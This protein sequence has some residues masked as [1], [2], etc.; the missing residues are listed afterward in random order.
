MEYRD[1]GRTGWKVS[2]IGFGAWAIGS[3]WGKVDETVSLKTLHKALDMGVNFFDT[4]DVYG[5]EPMVGQLRR[6]RSEP[7]YI[8]TK[9]GMQINPSIKGY[10]RRNL[11]AQLNDCLA[12]LG[13]ESIDLL[14]LHCPP[15]EVYNAGVCEILDDFV[16]QGKIRFY[17]TSVETLEQA[18]KASEFPNMQSVQL[19]FNV[20]RQKP[21]EGF[22]DLAKQRKVAIIARVPLASGLL[23]GKMSRSSKFPANDHRSFN[24]NGDAFDVGETFSGVEFESGLEAVEELRKFVPTTASMA[25]F[26]LRWILMFDA[27][28]CI[29][30][31][32]RNPSQV[33]DNVRAM[34]LA[35]LNSQTMNA[36]REIYDRRIRPQVHN[37]W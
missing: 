14:Q 6:E 21:I 18:V 19:I 26:A 32:G 9:I 13:V 11:T 27:V 28:S 20:F 3:M 23:T 10:N 8:A 33:E 16:K 29:I 24:R 31:G 12:N 34:D 36:V 7:F 17:G 5:S 35:S 1:F 37:R 30:P 4:A 2:P 25:Q 22:F 15:I